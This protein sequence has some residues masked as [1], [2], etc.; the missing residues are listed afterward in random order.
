MNCEICGKTIQSSKYLESVICSSEC[1]SA[2]Y[3][4]DR[5]KRINNPTQVVIDN[6]VY[7]IG[8]EDISKES[9]GFGGAVHFIKFNDGR[10][11]KTTNLWHNGKL[12]EAFRSMLPNNAVFLTA[13]E[14]ENL[15]GEQNG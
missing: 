15:L 7:Q 10:L 4:L 8:R 13:T 5:V 9:K 1:F 14:Y 2:K 11:I 12:P 6:T 3:W